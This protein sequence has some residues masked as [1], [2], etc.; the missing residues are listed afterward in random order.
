M[1]G[2]PRDQPVV[3][4]H[5]IAKE[6]AKSKIGEVSPNTVYE[7]LE[8][9]REEGMAEPADRPASE[10]PPLSPIEALAP[11]VLDEKEMKLQKNVKRLLRAGYTEVELDRLETNLQKKHSR[12][13]HSGIAGLRPREI[14]ALIAAKAREGFAPPDPRTKGYH[15][16]DKGRR[17]AALLKEEFLTT[18]WNDCIKSPLDDAKFLSELGRHGFEAHH[19]VAAVNV[20]AIRI[21][22][23][24][25]E[26]HPAKYQLGRTY[27]KGT[28]TRDI[29]RRSFR[30]DIP[31]LTQPDFASSE[32][33]EDEPII[34]REHA[35][36]LVRAMKLGKRRKLES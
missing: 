8:A 13:R 17:V 2:R 23:L 34:S 11:G 15:I 36:F 32:H 6:F 21:V 12:R 1:A 33:K 26:K 14:K 16:T 9:F 27:Y 22:P 24:E 10:K 20:R 3:W 7:A 31:D 19:V 28:Q 35:R 5:S 25:P 29:E 30:Y 18:R 4:G